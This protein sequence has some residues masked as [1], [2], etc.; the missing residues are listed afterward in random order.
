MTRRPALFPVLPRGLSRATSSLSAPFAP[1][2]RTVLA[3][4]GLSL[5]GAAGA[6]SGCANP[7]GNASPRTEFYVLEDQRRP[8]ESTAASL[9]T[10]AT[11]G[12][13]LMLASGATQA[14]F[15]SDRIVFMRDGV[16]RGYYAYANWS[17]RPT[18]RLVTLAENRLAASGRFKAVVQ[19]VSGV[20]GDLL[21][22]L[23]LEDL[24][25]NDS[26]TASRLQL[27]VSAEL[28]DW[29]THTLVQRRRFDHQVNLE[30]RNAAGAVQA[31]NRA[32]TDFLDQ[33]THWAVGAAAGLS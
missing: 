26:N 7:L 9:H 12:L 22:T 25:H 6:L 4:T 27:A 32:V 30:S 11:T 15:D 2:R 3:G 23:R 13:V 5:L 16:G 33:L 8:A 21:L 28:V 10:P 31:G 20:R 18:R 14:L 29:R 17:E 1:A 24:T 19:S